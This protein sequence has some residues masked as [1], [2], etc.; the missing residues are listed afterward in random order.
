L[1]VLLGLLALV[2]LYPHGWWPLDLVAVAV[3]FALAWHS[4]L[5]FQRVVD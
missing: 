5:L 3:L 1:R 4:R 2:L